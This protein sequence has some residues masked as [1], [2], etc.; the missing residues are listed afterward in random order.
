M[1]HAKRWGSLALC[2]ILLCFSTGCASKSVSY[3]PLEEDDGEIYHV[4]LCQDADHLYYN[5]IA[6]GFTDALSDL[7]GENHIRTD[8]R[9]V[10][11]ESSAEDICR[12]FVSGKTQLILANGSRSLSAATAATTETPIVGTGIMDFQ[13]AL[14]IITAPDVAWDHLTGT[15]VTGVSATPDIAQQL[16]LLIEATPNLNNVGILYSPEDTAA[17]YQNQL[18]E[19]YLNEAGI[20]WKEYQL[21]STAAAI[22][23]TETAEDLP[24]IRPTKTVAPSA[25]EGSD[26][27]VEILKGDGSAGGI[28]APSS[29]RPS[30]ISKFWTG[31]AEIP[32]PEASTED[33]ISFAARECSALYIP[34]E[35]NLADQ[36][37][38]IT[39]TAT[40][41]G[42]T[43]VAGDTSLGNHAL[44]TL[45]SD[46]YAMGYAAGK[47]VY[48]ILVGG[49]DPGSIKIN[50]SSTK[51][52][53][54]LYNRQAAEALNMSFPKSFTEYET[55]Q[56]TYE[57][58]S[59][60]ER[61][62]SDEEDDP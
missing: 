38:V 57:T 37:E 27:E 14:N 5:T 46:P 11:Q 47:M 51:Q 10:T 35:S 21:T 62:A 59:T 60:T 29:A 7:F 12:D 3:E 45:F 41:S 28:N 24:V 22:E 53:S 26:M 6:T 54:K 32:A 39:A 17:I 16:S 56:L 15:N 19:N 30:Q 36:M 55:F 40:R 18:L 33:I 58:G 44:V 1:R 34:A 20:P 23:H 9:T 31:S 48:R 42:V 50:T 4:S 61:I 52:T 13:R 8:I 2:A 49:E 43:T 25:R